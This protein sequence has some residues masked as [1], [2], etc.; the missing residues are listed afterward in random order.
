MLNLIA[1]KPIEKKIAKL[2]VEPL[3]YIDLELIRIKFFLN[4]SNK[5]QIFID[6]NNYEKIEISDCEKASNSISTILDVEDLIKSEYRLEVS[7]PG[8]NRPLTR[9]KDFEYWQG[10]K[11]NIKTS[12]IIENK[13]SFFGKLPA[14]VAALSQKKGV[15]C[16]II[17]G[18]A[19][20]KK[21]EGLNMCKI[22][23]CTPSDSSI[24]EAMKS[25]KINLEQTIT[26]EL[27][28]IKNNN[29]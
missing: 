2:I 26:K 15:P 14:Q 4:K 9:L 8:I 1:L 10:N 19:R 13:Q 22:I 18:K 12:E 6:K 5:L 3:E 28:Q 21:I 25:A 27:Y 17:V 29:S 16:L 23:E 24:D 7:S 11:I 20:V